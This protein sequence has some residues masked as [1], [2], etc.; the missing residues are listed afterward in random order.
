MG[1]EV[2]APALDKGLLCNKPYPTVND[3]EDCR[4]GN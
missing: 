2:A 4:Q 3:S 1:E